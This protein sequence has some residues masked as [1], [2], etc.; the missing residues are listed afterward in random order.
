MDSYWGSGDLPPQRADAQIAHA[1][2]GPWYKPARCG[3]AGAGGGHKRRKAH[4][5]WRAAAAAWNDMVTETQGLTAPG[6]GDLADLVVRVGRI[7]SGDPEWTPSAV[8]RAVRHVAPGGAELGVIVGTLHQ[9]VD[10]LDRLGAGELRAVSAAVQVKRV[11]VLTR[12]LPVGYDV[13]Y[14]FAHATP[15]DAQALVSTYQDACRATRRAR[16]KLAGLAAAVEAPSQTLAAARSAAQRRPGDKPAARRGRPLRQSDAAALL[17]PGSVERAVRRLRAADPVLLVRARA[18][19]KAARLLIA[20]AEGASRLRGSFADG[21]ISPS[22]PAA[23]SQAE[24]AA[25]SFPWRGAAPGA[26]HRAVDPPVRASAAR[27]VSNSVRPRLE[28]G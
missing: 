18:I 3:G 11:Y 8:Q 9:A 25:L 2:A 19:D 6:I 21:S 22:A 4:K 17:P 1:A 26:D 28:R 14:K 12:T 13:P 10:V 20:E 16:T 23:R 5:G 24:V 7:V 15:V 27:K